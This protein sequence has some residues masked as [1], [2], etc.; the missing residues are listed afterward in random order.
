MTGFSGGSS[1]LCAN[2]STRAASLPHSVMFVHLHL[3]LTCGTSTYNLS[4]TAL[5]AVMLEHMASWHAS[6]SDTGQFLLQ[7]QQGQPS[8]QYEA[9]SPTFMSAACP[10]AECLSNSKAEW[11]L[12]R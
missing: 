3:C 1:F 10:I 2:F 11:F 6:S 9:Q 12:S 5:A 7:R 4:A 8:L